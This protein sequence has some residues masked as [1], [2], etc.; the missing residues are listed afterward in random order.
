MIDFIKDQHSTSLSSIKKTF[1]PFGIFSSA[2]EVQYTWLQHPQKLAEQMGK[3]GEELGL[4]NQN[5]FARVYGANSDD[6]IPNNRYDERFKDDAW[7]E[8]LN[9]DLIKEHYLLYTHWLEDAIYETPGM[10]D[11]QRRKA[12]F[13]A[14]QGL[15]TLSPS[16]FF[17][18]N[19]EAIHRFIMSGGMSAIEGFK[20]L[21]K[22]LNEGEISMVDKEKFEVGKNV[23]STPGSVVFRNELLEVLQFSPSTEEVHTVPVV[24]VSPWINK[25][26]I[27][28]LNER[29]SMIQY[30]VSKGFTVFV[31]SWKNP[32]SDMRDTSVEDYMF[33]GINEIVRVA[34]EISG[35]NQVHAV[36][37]CIGG[38]MLSAYMAWMNRDRKP[39][40]Q[41]PVA[42]WTLFTS[43]VDFVEPGDIDVFVDEDI[44]EHL[45]KQMDSKGYLDGDDMAMS[46]RMLRSNSLIWNYVMKGYLFGEET[47]PLD[48]LFWNMDTTRLPAT[49]HSFYLREFYLNNKLVQP[50]ALSFN[51]RKID[52]G[53]IKQP[54]YSVGTEQDHIAPWKETFKICQQV[55]GPVNYTLATSGHILGIISPPVEPP[56]RKYWS[57]DASGAIDA[58]VWREG[59]EKVPGSWWD[60]WSQ[61]LSTNCGDKVE[62]RQPGS[63]DYPVLEAAPGSYV[64]ET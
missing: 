32:D 61:W 60:D 44:V 22:D 21:A 33:K 35:S 38:T 53:K 28:D 23:A 27:L 12:A 45:E 5:F 8:N 59:I 9:F 20:I 58:E 42:H 55:T 17:W 10:T 13:W 19:P 51:G 24:I 7:T 31:T 57:G 30:L 29:K 2:L 3:F 4:I 50:D 41:L 56:K 52:L 54:L 36:G 11:K 14:K 15:N 37:Y 34:G 64:R 1:D 46:F 49:M 48:V 26:Y 47:T 63:K 62:A 18:T 43:L 39:K 25:Y 16:N 40:S 6:L